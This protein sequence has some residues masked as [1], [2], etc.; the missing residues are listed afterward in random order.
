MVSILGP[1]ATPG[2]H[3]SGGPPQPLHGP[4]LSFLSSTSCSLTTDQA[5]FLYFLFTHRGGN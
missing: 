1:K 5:L 4:G 3:A 2:S